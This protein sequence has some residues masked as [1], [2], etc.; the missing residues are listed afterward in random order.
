MYKPVMRDNG[1]TEKSEDWYN[2]C[3]LADA[4]SRGV[5]RIALFVDNSG[6][7]T[8]D[9]VRASYDKFQKMLKENGFEAI[10]VIPKKREDYISTCLEAS[11]LS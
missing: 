10:E 11:T 1:D 8:T 6:T 4:R 2:I 3:G 7:M 5:T 9:T